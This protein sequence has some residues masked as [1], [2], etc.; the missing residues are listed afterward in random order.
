MMKPMHPVMKARAVAV[1]AAHAHLV[2]T[3]PHFRAQPPA[4]QFAATQAHIGKMAPPPA[5]VVA[6]LQQMA[7]APQLPRVP[8]PPVKGRG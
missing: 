5:Q 6:R 1:K 4:A 2:K 8:P 7:Q 3:V